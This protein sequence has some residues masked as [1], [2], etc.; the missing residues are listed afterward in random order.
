MKKGWTTTKL[1]AI[2]AIAVVRFLIKI[3]I[4]TTTLAVTGSVFAGLLALV[5]GPFFVTLVPLVFNQFGSVT[6]FTIIGLFIEL[7]LPVIWPKLVNFTVGPLTGLIV[8]VIFWKLKTKKRFFSFINGFIYNLIQA[9]V[10]I[11]LYFS[12]GLFGTQDVPKFLLVPVV[13]ATVTLL[14]SLLGGLSGYFAFLIYEK[15]KKTSVVKRI[16]A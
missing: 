4:Y 14:I 3:L 9:V 8:D 7:P 1:I 15:L 2:G 13:L 5:I 6:I 16:Q 10:S 12:I 11:A